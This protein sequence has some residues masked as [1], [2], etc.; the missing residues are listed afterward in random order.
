MTRVE[1]MADEMI[2]HRMTSK[3]ECTCGH[4]YRPGASIMLHRAEVMDIVLILH[5][6]GVERDKLHEAVEVVR[7][8][9]GK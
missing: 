4:Y 3:G 7:N 8:L 6:A 2:Y 1:A 9:T 5:E